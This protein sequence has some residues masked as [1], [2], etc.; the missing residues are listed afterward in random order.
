MASSTL[1]VKL[2]DILQDCKAEQRDQQVVV[3]GQVK[4]FSGHLGLPKLPAL[5]TDRHSVC[6]AKL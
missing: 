1:P 5:C 4:C 3:L 2:L 6:E